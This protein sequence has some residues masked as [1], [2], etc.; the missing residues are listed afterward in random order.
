MPLRVQLPGNRS[1]AA[2]WLLW[3]GRKVP[4]VVASS[5]TGDAWAAVGAASL[6]AATNSVGNGYAGVTLTSINSFSSARLL[7]RYPAQP[8]LSGRTLTAIRFR[9]H[10]RVATGGAAVTDS[11]AFLRI[12]GVSLTAI[13][14]QNLST[15]F[16]SNSQFEV[17]TYT[18]NAADLATLGVTAASIVSGTTELNLGASATGAATLAVDFVECEFSYSPAPDSSLDYAD[19]PGG[20][21]ALPSGWQRIYTWSPSVPALEAIVGIEVDLTAW[22]DDPNAADGNPVRQPEYAQLYASFQLL[23]SQFQLANAIPGSPNAYLYP[24]EVAVSLDGINPVGETWYILTSTTVQKFTCGSASYLWARAGW[25]PADFAGEFSVLVRR[26]S[27][28]PAVSS[29]YVTAARV[30]VTTQSQQGSLSMP[31]RQE[32]T[33]IVLLGKESTPGTLAS[34]FQRMRAL[35]YKSRPNVNMKSYRPVG[36]K[37]TSVKIPVQEWATGSISGLL[38]YNEIAIPL[39]AIIGTGVHGGTGIINQRNYH[40]YNL[41]NRKRSVFNTYSLQRGET[42]TRAH[43]HKYLVHTGLQ[44][45]IA[46][47]DCQ[48]SGSFLSRPIEDGITMAAGANEVQTL[49]ITGTPTG[50]TYRLAFRGAETTDLA[51]NAL[52]A[53]IQTALQALPTIG[54]GNALVTGTGPWTVSFAAGLAGENQPLIALVRNNL[55]G[56]TTPTLAVTEATRGGYARYDLVP[57]VPGHWN[58]YMADTQAALSGSQLDKSVGIVATGI[59]VTDR[60]NAFFT[61]DR[62]AAGTFTDVSEMDPKFMANFTVA[63]NSQGMALMN[64]I[65]AGA[66]KWLR[67][68]AVGPVIGATADFH[69]IIWEGTV[70]VADTSDF[71]NDDGMVVYPWQL[72]W[73]EGPNGE[74]PTLV[75]ENGV[76]SY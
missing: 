66:T 6:L 69:K 15:W 53:A 49:T 7:P 50:G 3:T 16:V 14:K 71:G 2:D 48:V 34:S 59:S 18:W 42:T 70:K 76:V 56:G 28:T 35:N 21:A 47:G 61:L 19:L 26:P 20:L 44:I 54:A 24:L 55:T 31:F 12:N 25:V 63:A 32:L 46:S 74:V 38:D 13:N 65:R 68:E 8:Q 60:Y 67:L 30:R 9:V 37:M 52:A 75:I 11:A 33:E 40:Q 17:V 72:E 39:E 22:T 45:Q 10:R 62:G 58:I 43:G 1:T 27:T 64:T 23:L 51:Y 36:E 5:G 29:Q 41:E 73:C 4:T 57:V